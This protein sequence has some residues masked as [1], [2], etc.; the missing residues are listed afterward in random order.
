MIASRQRLIIKV[1]GTIKQVKSNKVLST[2]WSSWRHSESDQQTTEPGQPKLLSMS[3]EN[4]SVIL[5]LILYINL[6]N[7]KVLSEELCV[8]YREGLIFQ[9]L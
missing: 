1:M 4:K 9:M 8:V 7:Y 2:G 3:T 5:I 6:C